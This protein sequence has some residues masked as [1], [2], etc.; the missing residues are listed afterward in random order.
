VGL[1]Q[2]VIDEYFSWTSSRVGGIGTD[3]IA[4]EVLLRHQAAF[5]ERPVE[6]HALP[7]GG[8]YQWRAE[9][10]YHLFNPETIH[11]LQKAVRTG[12]YETFKSYS[13]LID[14]QS[15]N[16]CTLRGLLEFKAAD[17]VPLEEVE[18]AAEI[19]RRF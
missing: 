7:A 9:G 15:T 12:S 2:D 5:P 17:P 6:R 11:R 18:P 8:Q 16:L 10:E 14:E 3:V 1:R 13:K 19:M 4:Q